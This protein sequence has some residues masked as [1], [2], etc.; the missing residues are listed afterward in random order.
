MGPVTAADRRA[1]LA[2]ETGIR[3]PLAPAVRLKTMGEM[4]NRRSTLCV[5]LG[6]KT[7]T[8]AVRVESTENCAPLSNRALIRLRANAIRRDRRQ[9]GCLGAGIEEKKVDDVLLTKSH[10]C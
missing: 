10:Q 3:I 6:L 2:Q 8:S 7:C 9:Y 5:S 4:F 1:S